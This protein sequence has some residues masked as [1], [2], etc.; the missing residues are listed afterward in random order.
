VVTSA[1]VGRAKGRRA[2]PA[3]AT[4]T[5]VD[6]SVAE[7]LANAR[8][9]P[10]LFDLAP[11]AAFTDEPGSVPDISRLV[12]E[13]RREGGRHT[14]VRLLVDDGERHLALAAALAEALSCD[15][16]LTP[17]NTRLRYRREVSPVTGVS[18]DAIAV[19]RASGEPAEWRVARP[20]DLPPQ[21]PTWY[22]TARGRLR[23]RTGLVS[24]PLPTGLAFP[25]KATYRDT[26]SLAGRMRDASG[27]PRRSWST[28]RSAGSRSA[29]SATPGRC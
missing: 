5:S 16:F 20:A 14:D 8:R 19:D 4:E 13:V 17:D 15:V 25:T 28:P 7:F 26:A 11:P 12:T 6:V 10:Q 2:E 29:A 1:A 22:V 9:Q 24:V 3:P 23:P 18:F 21:T 27:R